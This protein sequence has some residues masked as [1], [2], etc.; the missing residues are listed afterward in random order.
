MKIYEF[1]NLVYE[2]NFIWNYNAF[3]INKSYVYLKE[4]P[5]ENYQE[6]LWR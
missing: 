1:F 5:P 6:F 4:K 2:L 3:I